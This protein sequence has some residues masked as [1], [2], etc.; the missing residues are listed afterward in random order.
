ARRR[1]TGRM[2]RFEKR[3]QRCCLRR[4]QILAVRRHIAPAQNYLPNQLILCQPHRHLI[5]SWTAL[6]TAFAQRMAVPALFGLKNQGALPLQTVSTA[7]LLFGN[8]LLPHEFMDRAHG[9]CWPRCVNAPIATA[10]SSTARTAIGRRFQLFSP[11]P[12]RNGR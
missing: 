12:E 10:M 1:L 8:W 9:V 4:S 7:K 5:E 2:K 6:S 3:N 11:S